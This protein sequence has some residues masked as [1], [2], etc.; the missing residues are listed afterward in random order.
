M[1][2]A[3]FVYDIYWVFFTPVMIGVAKN[4]DGPIKLMFQTSAAT[5]DSDA[6]FSIL[7]LGDI[8][9]PG[10]SANPSPFLP[11]LLSPSLPSSPSLPLSLPPSLPVVLVRR[12]YVGAHPLVRRCAGIF[13]A[14]MLRY[15]AH[16]NS[17]DMSL[18]RHEHRPYKKTVFNTTMLGYVIGLAVTLVVMLKYKHGQ[19]STATVTLA[20]AMPAVVAARWSSCSVASVQCCFVR[21]VPRLVVR[22][23]YSVSLCC[24]AVYCLAMLC[25]RAALR[26]V[27]VCV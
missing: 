18:E 2:S 16:M 27:C 10:M 15:D 7:G 3:L 24:A 1:Q 5:I 19:A 11:P 13:I 21:R 6:T 9:L 8:V 14:L 20:C 17:V 4:I 26:C 23:C 12:V 22:C 25:R